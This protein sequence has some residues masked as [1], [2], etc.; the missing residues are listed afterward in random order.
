LISTGKSKDSLIGEVA[1]VVGEKA[2]AP[3]SNSQLSLAARNNPENLLLLCLIHHKIIDD[4]PEFYTV[5]RI[6]EIRETHIEQIA[7]RL[8]TPVR[9]KIGISQFCY[10]NVPRLDEYAALQGVLIERQPIDET[11]TLRD[12]NFALTYL[13]EDYKRS[14]EKLTIEAIPL[15]QVRFAHELYIGQLVSLENARFRTKNIP[16]QRLRGVSRSQFSGNLRTDPHIYCQ[17][18]SWRLVVNI[19]P[20]WITTDTAYGLFRPPGGASNFTGFVRITQVD[21]Q[22]NTMM[23]TGQALGLPPSIFDTFTKTPART[24]IGEMFD[25][26]SQEEH[27]DTVSRGEYFTDPPKACD[28]C[29]RSF[30]EEKYLLDAQIAHSGRAWAFMCEGCFAKH[31]IGLGLGRGQRYRATSDGWLLVA[32]AATP[33]LI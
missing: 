10:L 12:L 24:T 20:R 22:T 14:L 18:A 11:K 32:G 9:W 25:A 29:G 26:S 4:D 6:L 16:A 3:R 19:D 5:E 33:D 8:S 30:A 2:D 28:I 31:A 15:N 23:A 21:Y 13:M 1:H 27:P 7:K 17:L